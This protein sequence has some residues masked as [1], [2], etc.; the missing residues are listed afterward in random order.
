MVLLFPLFFFTQRSGHL[1]VQF[2]MD[3]VLFFLRVNVALLYVV[4]KKQNK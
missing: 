3:C 4:L 1:S 2:L